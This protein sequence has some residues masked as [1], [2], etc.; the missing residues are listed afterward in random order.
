MINKRQIMSLIIGLF[1][2]SVFVAGGT[3]AY[4]SWTSNTNKSVIF[5]TAKEYML[6]TTKSPQ[7]LVNSM[8]NAIRQ[9]V[10]E[11]EQSDDLT[12]LAVQYKNM[13]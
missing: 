10:G 8:N 7:A 6:E 4:F 12:M 3:Y 2:L 9:F 1:L 5:N 11:A 13:E